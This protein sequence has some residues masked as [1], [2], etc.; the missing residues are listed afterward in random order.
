MISNGVQRG[1][2]YVRQLSTSSDTANSTGVEQ[3]QLLIDE[4]DD[5][6]I[7]NLTGSDE[8][9]IFGPIDTPKSDHVIGKTVLATQAYVI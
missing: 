6:E 2:S 4:Q 7:E 3:K 1:I 8:E 9:M 5:T